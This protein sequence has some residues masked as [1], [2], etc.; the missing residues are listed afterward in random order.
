[1]QIKNFKN[2][3]YLVLSL[4]LLFIVIIGSAIIVFDTQEIF[5]EQLIYSA[6]E[7]TEKELSDFLNPITTSLTTIR[8]DGLSNK[9]NFENEISL[10]NYFIPLLKKRKNISTVL[11]LNSL[12]QQYLLYKEGNTSVSTYRIEKEYNNEV[13]WKRWKSTG[14]KLSEWKQNIEFDPIRQ[15][16][17]KKFKSFTKSETVSWFGVNK[18][19]GLKTKGITG[20]TFWKR[21][22]DGVIFACGMDTKLDDVINNLNSLKIYSDPNPFII[23]SEDRIIPLIAEERDTSNLNIRGLNDEIVTDSVIISFISDWENLGKDSSTT[24]TLFHNNESWWAQVKPLNVEHSN[25]KLGLV[26]T[27]EEL[28]LAELFGNYFYFGIL[29]G[30]SL[31]LLVLFIYKN[32]KK[33]FAPGEKISSE[34]LIELLNEGENSKF[35]LKSSLRWDYR[36][37]KVNKKLEEV[38]LKSIS[39]FNNAEGGNLVIGIDDDK[40]ILGLENDYQTLKKHGSD[41][42]ELHLRNLIN[43]TFSVRFSSRKVSVSFIEVENIEVCVIKIKKGEYPLFFKTKDKDGKNLEKFFIRSGNSSQEITSLS[44]VNTYINARFN[45]D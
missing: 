34:K 45:K 3:R 17:Y 7:K 25:L 12:G 1:M 11:Y 6:T 30:L 4:L 32:Y 24:F 41:Y 23:T 5:T 43:S 40:K 26:I 39:A 37:E 42:F 20:I 36:E 21:E 22:S 16:W 10:N 33:G 13:I 15:N 8:E 2:K 44:E 29:L 27:E 18:L 14:N 38:I 31:M 35:E 28:L 19:L 9:I